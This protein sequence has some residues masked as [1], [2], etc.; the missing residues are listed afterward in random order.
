MSNPRNSTGT[1]LAELATGIPAASRVFR[2]VG[3]DYCCSGNRSLA[4][5][6]RARGL[7]ADALL[8]E[9]GSEPA[10]ASPDVDWSARP[11]NELVE[12]ILVR[13]HE[14]LRRELPELMELAR[15]VER[16][17]A[18]KASVPKGLHDHLAMMH[19]EVLDHLAK[20]EQVL[21]PMILAGQGRRAGAPVQVME[22][23]HKDHGRNLARVRELT[24][25]LAPPA[26]ACTTWRAL[27]LRLAAL[28]GEL[29][30]HIHLENNVLFPRALC[31]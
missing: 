26:E 22:H 15:K 17:H 12:H 1:T 27:Y 21:F 16:V 8:R 5:A 13:Y 30:D 23:E 29:M 28:E 9:I 11:L 14:P 2:R 18:E 10:G 3:L 6:C 4:E 19:A 31:E 24:G 25:D 20:E 7:D